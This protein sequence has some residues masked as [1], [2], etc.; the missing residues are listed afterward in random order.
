MCAHKK[1]YVS[2]VVFDGVWLLKALQRQRHKVLVLPDLL[3]LDK[4]ICPADIDH[5]FSHEENAFSTAVPTQVKRILDRYWKYFLKKIIFRDIRK[6]EGK[7]MLCV[8]PSR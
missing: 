5:L 4:F 8:F 2:V 3:S 7:V 1:Y 6:A